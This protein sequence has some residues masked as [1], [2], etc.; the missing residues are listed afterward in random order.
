LLATQGRLSA[1]L[2]RNVGRHIDWFPLIRLA[3]AEGDAE[4]LIPA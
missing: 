3:T 1:A 4:W 2:P